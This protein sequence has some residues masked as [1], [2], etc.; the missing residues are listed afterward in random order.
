MDLARDA[1]PDRLNPGR[2]RRILV[3]SLIGVA[4]RGSAT[5]GTL[6][7]FP[8]VL[9]AIGLRDFGLWGAAA[10]LSL[11][12]NF[13]DFGLGPMLI[14]FVARELAAGDTER[15]RRVFG[16]SVTAAM[17]IAGALILLSPAVFAL[18][19][20]HLEAQIFTIVTI[21]IA[22]NV[23]LGIANPAWLALQRGWM[24][25]LWEFVQTGIFV[26]SLY[27]CSL[28]SSD[29]RLFAAMIYIAIVLSNAFNIAT[30]V[31]VPIG[32]RPLRVPSAWRDIREIIPTSAKYFFLTTLDALSYVFDAAIALQVAG[33]LAAGQM[34]IIQ[35]MAVAATGVLL[36]LSQYLWP[37][38]VEAA[39][40]GDYRWIKRALTASILGVGAIATVI[41]GVLAFFGPALCRVWLHKDIGF[42][43]STFSYLALWIFVMGA[44]R[45]IGTVL[46][47]LNIL[48]FQ[49]ASFSVF[50]VVSLILKFILPQYFGVDG[51]L[52][53]VILPGAFLLIPSQLVRLRSAV[54]ARAATT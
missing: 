34:S 12:I 7:I 20:P 46:N 10:S 53:A 25:A 35:R 38:Y 48:S 29:V 21:G 45:S 19:K 40:R 23:P 28:Y 50:I 1:W 17:A 16:A 4:Q 49:I 6:L 39:V 3:T 36:I 42:R 32:I 22:L 31:S 5:L 43:S 41:F 15:A 47:A 14:T 51:I 44:S 37:T 11:I 13:A 24:C 52:I 26:V 18:T 27:L 9:H 2:A 33:A 8:Q 30:L 54:N